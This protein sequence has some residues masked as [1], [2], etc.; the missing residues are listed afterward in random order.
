MSKNRIGPEELEGFLSTLR[1]YK[2]GKANLESRMIKNEEWW[3]L[4]N[5]S[6]EGPIGAPG[7]YRARSG[8]LHNVITSKHA[9]GMDALPEAAL[10]AREPGD[11]AEAAALSRILPC[12][13]EQNDFEST[14]SDVL[15]QKLKF[16]TGCYKV[17]WDKERLHGLGDV[18]I[19]RVN[20]LNLFWEP[21]ITDLRDSR[22]LFHTELWDRELLEEEYPVCRGKTESA[23]TAE[24]FLYDDRVSTEG[25]VT[26]VDVWYHRGRALHYC[27]FVGST[28]LYASENDPDCREQGFYL[29]GDYPF[30]LDP[31][32]PIEGSPCGYGFIDLCCA[33]QAEIDLLKTAIVH[34]A[35]VGT[36]PRY[37]LRTDGAVNEEE[38]LDL[39]R[40]LI[41]VS[42]NLG[43]DS[44][45]P[46][47]V[48]GLSGAALALLNETVEE[49]RETTGT[50]DTGSGTVSVNMAA[51]AIQA[52]QDA[53]GKLSRDSCQ[54]TFRA[55]RK[56]V[57]LAL[58]L[59]RQFYTVP[60]A[61]RITG[62]AGEEEYLHY[63]NAGLLPRDQGEAFG[64][65]LG[66]RTP[67][68]DIR[69]ETQRKSAYST[70]AQN[71]LAI[72]LF[73]A[74]I[75][76]PELRDQAV[77]TLNMMNFPGKESLIKE[78]RAEQ[79]R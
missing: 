60:R 59:I 16:G 38:Y 28:V 18:A 43:E 4:H 29:H 61:F 39:S 11:E 73:R 14:F 45:R 70:L 6:M 41:H 10:L 37:F 26:V 7:S 48:N 1:E 68:F 8:W 30:V 67:S 31:L 62:A 32:F 66:S 17:F 35:M 24:K 47:P 56:I 58:E 13:L 63:S 3:K 12:I 42:G 23:F 21:G 15:W 19:R 77:L 72:S 36:V 25:K 5:V 34:N 74:G 40:P 78:L 33:Q 64:V 71:E 49:L 27:R 50:T 79:L 22:Y 9:D 65:R 52:L 20:L 46:V 75:F 55:F 76:R 2:A 44:I 53:S 69:V 51:S 54:G 57:N